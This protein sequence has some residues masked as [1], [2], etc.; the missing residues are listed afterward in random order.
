MHISSVSIDGGPTPDA[1]PNDRLNVFNIQ[2][3]CV[4]DGP[5]VR[6]TIFFQGCN[7]RCAWCQNPE[8]HDYCSTDQRPAGSS[9]AEI[10]E[11][12]RRDRR[13]YD[14]TG[15]GVTFSG[16]EAMMQHRASLVRLARALHEDGIHVAVETA[17]DAPWKTFEAMLPW[18]D[19]FLFDLKAP[20][21]DA[22]HM[23]LVGRA[24]DLPMENLRRLVEA[25]ANIRFRM[26]VVPGHNDTNDV[27]R[28]TAELLKSVGHD[29]IAVLKYY[30]IHE[31]KARRLGLA[32]RSLHLTRQQAGEALGRATA[33]FDVL[34]LKVES[35]DPDAPRT[36]TEFT[37]RVTGIKKALRDDGYHLCME[38]ATL[39]TRYYKKH[40]FKEPY[41]L[42][43]AEL[44]RHLLNNKKIVIYPD[45]LLV[46]N[47]TARR[48]GAQLWVE[49]F[50]AMGVGNIYNCDKQTPIPFQCSQA[51]KARFYLEMAP[52]WA[53][54]AVIMKIF[55]TYRELG[56]YAARLL[57]KKYGFE[58]NMSG[59]SHFIMN[60]ERVLKLGTD[61]IR[62]EV[63][64]AREEHDDEA[65]PFYDAV[66]TS[67]TALEEFAARYAKHLSAMARRETD[68]ARKA[69]LLD[70]A[71]ICRRVPKYP[72][73]TFHEALQA[74]LFIEIGL[75]IEAF[76]NAISFGRMDQIL[77]PYY[78]DDVQAGRITYEKARELIALFVLKIDEIIF[79]NDGDTGLQLG[80]LFETVSPTETITVGGVDADG[81]DATNDVTFMILDACKLHPISVNMAAR[82]HSGSPDAYVKR[83]AEVYLTGTPMPEL[84]N[85]DVYL[86]AMRNWYPMTTLEQNRNYSIVGC[87]EP[88]A[89]TEHFGN[90]D[91]ANVNLAMPFLQA[92]TG[93]EKDLWKYGL[94]DG[95]DKK[96]VNYAAER[97]GRG[98]RMPTEDLSGLRKK[99]IDPPATMDELMERF[100]QRL[101]AVT[102][103]VLADHYMIE[104]ALARHLPVPLASSLF[105]SAV[106]SGRD[107]LSGGAEINTNGIQA[108]GETDVADSLHAIDELVF[109][110]RAFTIYELVAAMDGNFQGERGAQIHAML[111]AVPKFGNDSS[112]AP[113]AWVNRVMECWVKALAAV[114]KCTRGGRYVAGYYGLNVNI[115]YGKNTPA[116][117]SG[118]LAG[119]P[120]AN[121]VVPHYGMKMVDLTSSM[122]AVASVD[123]PKYAPNGTTNT[124]T[125]DPALFPCESGVANLA[126]MIRAYFAQG[127]MQFQ[128]NVVSR[129]TLLDAYNNPDKYP[130]LVVRIAGYCAY[131]NDLSDELKMEII[132]RTYYA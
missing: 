98:R 39:K 124:A 79:F 45:E 64:A 128:P 50:S 2:R 57:Q 49:Y 99:P 7:M 63:L 56:L 12:V 92:L 28:A 131:F 47:F 54:N 27:F 120:L 13:F 14:L 126:G 1:R 66:L 19:L 11:V 34:G 33:A 53:T 113:A 38:T 10:L 121:S 18:V 122:N 81:R 90:T 93:D 112:A 65:A 119:V 100:Q 130:N 71:R 70:M 40:G 95:L 94:L 23:K 85:D 35:L 103:A 15:G 69:E 37:P 73:R 21:D 6:T 58:N 52:F 115:A 22:L 36:E 88:C 67:L 61:G 102:T 29:T 75:C 125:I 3:T 43:R 109:K 59:V 60:S 4:H 46:G 48:V 107:V 86:P 82:I 116:L 25:G 5:G 41:I 42:Q 51:E 127:G 91:C 117:P 16:G 83:L 24:P 129:E 32:D 62:Q 110:R 111:M 108:V 72:A 84:F 114:P 106:K 55:P 30:D 78:R 101:N 26:C 87:V 105:A 104:S 68:E 8:S 17:G 118:R 9:I 123:F 44:L 74:I 77:Y 89:S 96:A 97:L 20:G 80:K 132:N 31:S 76:E